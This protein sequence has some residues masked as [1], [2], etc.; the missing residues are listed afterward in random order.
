M[1]QRIIA[2][3]YDSWCH[4]ARGLQREE[5]SPGRGVWVESEPT[6]GLGFGCDLWPSPCVSCVCPSN[7]SYQGHLGT[8]QT[9][10]SRASWSCPAG[11]GAESQG[12][13]A[14][15]VLGGEGGESGKAGGNCA[16]SRVPRGMPRPGPPACRDPSP[17][18]PLK[19]RSGG[20]RNLWALGSEDVCSVEADGGDG[21]R[22]WVRGGF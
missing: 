6:W 11:P 14:A 15:R 5:M 19:L 4:S 9:A 13:D 2:Q 17:H 22:Q 20:W 8:R 10:A 21:L 16:K 12:G 7:T 3:Q 18:I 1:S